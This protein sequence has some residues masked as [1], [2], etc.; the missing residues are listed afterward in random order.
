MV[1]KFP[2]LQKTPTPTED[3][4]KAYY[5]ENKNKFKGKDSAT[6]RH[7]LVAVRKNEKETDKL[8]DEEARIKIAKAKAE[9]TGGKSWEE[10]AKE[11]S[12]DPGSKENGGKYENF[13][14]AQMVPEF[15]EAV[16]NQELGVI[17]EPI[18]TQ[19]GY[20]IILVES[21]KIGQIQTFN[22]ARGAAQKELADKMRNDAWKNFI[23]SL[24][25]EL[26]YADAETLAS[27]PAAAPTPKAAPN[28]TPAVKPGGGKR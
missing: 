25:T 26:G 14:P 12:D 23:D 24:K 10:V 9:L 17:G 1:S 15:A 7:I 22:E 13:N 8:T 5:E 18:K 6:A 21:R 28:K 27:E 20:H 4:I 3:Q 16:R 11:Y 19:Y 2:E